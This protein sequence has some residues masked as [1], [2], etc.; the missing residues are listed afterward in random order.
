M[1]RIDETLLLLHEKLSSLTGG[2]MIIG[3]ASLY[4]SEYPVEPN[5]IDILTD[6]DTAKT[7]A[8]LLDSYK[9]ETQVKPNDK[10]RSAFSEYDI[11]GFKV[12]VM[13]NL[14]VNARDGWVLLSDQIANAQTVLL[15]NKT[16]TVP[17]KEDQRRIY[18]LF[19]RAK[20][21][22]VLQLLYDT[23]ELR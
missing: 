22:P 17:A 20:D 10:F 4:L 13:G 11:N 15:L 2:W 3:T 7:I 19:N 1:N 8:G 14:E 5:D 23:K 21:E 16:F 9:V 6:I 18:T 12:E